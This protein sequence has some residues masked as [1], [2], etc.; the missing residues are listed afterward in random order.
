MGLKFI[1]TKNRNRIENYHFVNKYIYAYVNK[2]RKG[3]PHPSH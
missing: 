1:K 3:K 2:L